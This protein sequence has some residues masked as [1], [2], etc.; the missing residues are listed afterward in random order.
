MSQEYLRFWL[1]RFKSAYLVMPFLTILLLMVWVKVIAPAESLPFDVVSTSQG[2]LLENPSFEYWQ[3]GL[4]SGWSVVTPKNSIA[5]YDV[6]KI[7][8]QIDGSGLFVNVPTL[9]QGVVEISSPRININP[10]SQYF[11]KSFYKTD[12]SV[13]IFAKYYYQDGNTSYTLVKELPDYDYDLSSM[14]AVIKPEPSARSMQIIVMVNSIG[15]L[16]MDSAY[17]TR[18]SDTNNL[19]TSVIRK[20]KPT[21]WNM[22]QS[23]VSKTTSS[24]SQQ[25]DRVKLQADMLDTTSWRS[26][27][28]TVN[29]SELY[30]VNFEYEA[31]NF[32]GVWVD[33]LRTDG[34]EFS[35]KISDLPPSPY[36]SNSFIDVEIPKDVIAFQVSYQILEQG[37]LKTDNVFL[38]RKEESKSFISP[39]ISVTFDDGW[40]SGKENGTEILSEMG[41]MKATY[42]INPGLLNT[43]EVMTEDDIRQLISQGHQI[44]SHTNTHIDI[45][46]YEPDYVRS[47]MIKS[48]DFLHSLGIQQ[49]DFASPYGKYDYNVMDQ[50]M[51]LHTSHRGTE[52][53]INTKH[54]L[55]KSTLKGLFIRKDTTDAELREYVSRTKETNGWLILIYHKIEASDSKFDVD[56]ET[57]QRHM[58]I[59]KESNIPVKTVRSTLDGLK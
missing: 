53:G 31:T 49:I 43:P 20:Q 21:Y 40:S 58:Q 28:I 35:W 41:D 11:F 56:R 57:F 37:S 2:N 22:N 19:A 59:V 5:E 26:S 7:S 30:G 9:Q 47:E 55:D 1:N 14:S 23:N 45:T 10:N 51:A 46:S 36:R 32:V 50:V 24:Y 12:T 16:D 48:N 4:P 6:T 44:G 3:N 33:F 39:A 29:P 38:S 27:W 13:S 34:S 42:Y 15:Y 8:G 17:V 52:K 25:P 18:K 54:N